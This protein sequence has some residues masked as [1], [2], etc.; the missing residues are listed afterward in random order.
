MKV[1]LFADDSSAYTSSKTIEA[2]SEVAYNDLQN[3]S[4]W[5][6]VNQLSLNVAKTIFLA[7]SKNRH[8]DTVQIYLNG[9]TISQKHLVIFL[10]VVVDDKLEWREHINHTSM[11]INSSL[12]VLRDARDCK[13]QNTSKILYYTLIY[14]HLTTGLHLWGSTFK[15]FTDIIC[16]LQKRPSIIPNIVLN[17]SV[18]N[19]YTRGTQNHIQF[20][21]VLKRLE[22]VL[23]IW[24]YGIGQIFPET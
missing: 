7:I 8:I 21:D 19:Y 17:R 24:A 18:H 5:F 10:G 4:E 22:A 20:I 13:N 14:P 9:N 15:T 2:L 23:Q 3:L 1:I 6:K 16:T 12:F 11:K